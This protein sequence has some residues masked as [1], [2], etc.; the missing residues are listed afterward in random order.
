MGPRRAAIE[1]GQLGQTTER[2]IERATREWDAE[3]AVGQCLKKLG[4]KYCVIHDFPLPRGSV[5]HIVIGPTG[6]FVVET[7]GHVGEVSISD[8]SIRINGYSPRRDPIEQA[9]NSARHVRGCL[10]EDV[11]G[12]AWVRG[13]V[14][15]VSFR[16]AFQDS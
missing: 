2:I 10:R 12:V 3:V 7:N 4:S 8:G 13:M 6:V 14:R 5:D 9:R 11:D 1:A 16:G 15:L